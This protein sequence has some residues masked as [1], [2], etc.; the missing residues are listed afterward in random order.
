MNPAL[1]NARVRSELENIAT[2]A[3]SRH[4]KIPFSTQSNLNLVIASRTRGFREI[5]L[6]ILIARLLDPKYKASSSFYS[7]NPRA[8]YEGP[9]R[10]FLEENAIPHHKSGPL[11]IAKAAAG[12]NP[13]WAAQRTPKQD[14]D[15]TVSLVN[16]IEGSTQTEVRELAVATIAQLLRE[17]TRIQSLTVEVQPEKDP[18]RLY[19]LCSH[20]I[21]DVPDSGNTPQRIIGLLL[22]TYH[23]T[24]KTGIRVTGHQDRAST[25]STTSKKP[26]DI[27]EEGNGEQVINVYEVT[28]KP[29]DQSRINESYETVRA[30]DTSHSVFIPEVIVICRSSD[31]HHGTSQADPAAGYLGRVDFQDLTY[32]FVEIQQWVMQQLLRM[33]PQARL[34]FHHRL[35][36]YISEPNTAESVKKAWVGLHRQALH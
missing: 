19:Y 3:R 32:L 7:C 28:V 25:T 8:L 20:L 16:T 11:N 2:Q 5:L 13:Q 4:A 30:Y 6:V 24:L 10:S 18:H 23:E 27:I 33:P 15:A 9:I 36:S 14:A 22:S 35:H 31:S 17:A 1:R 29:F 21:A 34:T 26:G 12:I